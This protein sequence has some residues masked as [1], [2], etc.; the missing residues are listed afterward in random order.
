MASAAARLLFLCGFRVAILERESP[1]AVRRKVS[2]AEAVFSGD[3]TVEG[4]GSRRVDAGE[5]REA[6]AKGDVVPVAVD[7]EA[8]CLSLIGASVLVDG[9]MAKTNLGTDLD[10]AALVIGLGPGFVAGHDV[11]AVVET[12]R[13]PDLGHVIWTGAARED[14]AH[15][16]PVLGYSDERVLKAPCSGRFRGRAAIGD[17]V[18]EGSIV[19]DVDGAPIRTEIDGLLRGLL[20]DGVSISQ[21]TKVGDVDPRGSAVD[22]G[23]VSD[24]AR[25]VAAGTLEAVLLGL[26]NLPS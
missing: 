9:R 20:G 15:P 1:L 2:F 7:P 17:L 21:G 24:K 16:S 22:P 10:Q 8:T 4:V 6:L 5:L 25:A 23:R 14:S 3:A 26:R 18:T 12:Q 13:G 11:N 19:G